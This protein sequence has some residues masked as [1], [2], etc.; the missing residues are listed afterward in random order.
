MG[1][2]AADAVHIGDSPAHDV[3]G[4]HRAGL[5]AIWVNR[6]RD[7]ADAAHEHGDGPT[8]AAELRP[9]LEVPSLSAVIGLLGLD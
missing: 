3:A 1:A 4:A 5:G 9:T 8:P 2:T 7:A 6:R